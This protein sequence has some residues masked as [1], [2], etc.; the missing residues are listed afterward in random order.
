MKLLFLV[1][2]AFGGHG[3]ISRFNQDFATALSSAPGV[4]R[5]VILPRRAPN[6]TGT[7]PPRVE[8]R[9]APSGKL[10]FAA[11]ALTEACR[12]YDAVICG[13]INLLPAAAPAARLAGRDTRL[14]LVI[15]GVDA[16]APVRGRS[17]AGIDLLNRIDLTIAVSRYTLDRFRAWSGV[18]PARCVVLP[19]TV[20]PTVF[21]PGPPPAALAARYG[22]DGGGPVVMGLARLDLLDPDKG[23]E[24]MFAALPRLLTDFPGLRYLVCG[25]GNG[26]A[27]LEAE[28][29]RRGLERQ[30]IFT[31]FVDETEKADHYRLADAFVLCGRQE[32]FG[33][34]LLEAMACGV[35]AVASVRDGSR[36]AVLD[37]AIGGLADPDDPDDLARAV[38]AALTQPR[39][40]VPPALVPAFGPA[41]FTRRV[42]GLA[43]R[44]AERG[45]GQP[46]RRNSRSA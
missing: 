18:D 29:R 11:A 17:L 9:A 19:N 7:L 39:G 15:H 2:D 20:D 21:T 26:R 43:E 5:L 41:A 37:G 40:T 45:V 13:H 23:F 24:E 1:S 6:P 27:R 46:V 30:V 42:H 32:G 10:G 4:D 16:W 12:G 31:G 36:E 34:V 8:Q 25:D 3:G 35:P 38:A 44:L 28:A 14:G 33:I 22:L